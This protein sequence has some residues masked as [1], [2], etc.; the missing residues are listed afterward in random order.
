MVSPNS[1]EDTAGLRRPGRSFGP[2]RR[3]LL[4]IVACLA[5]VLA[6]AL[7]ALPWWLGPV[8]GRV[9]RPWGASFG[10]YER[11]G[12]TRF[13]LREVEVRQPGVRVAVSRV[14]S[15]TP[16]V[17]LWRRA[18]GRPGEI[19][20]E[21]WTVN[22]D[23][24]QS[25]AVATP[26]AAEGGWMPLRTTLRRI[27]NGLARWLPRA[28]AGAG[29]VRWPGG[30]LTLASA[31]WMERTLTV[32]RLELG[33]WPTRVTLTFPA[34]ADLLRLTFRTIDANGSANL[35]SREASVTGKVN[36]WE[37]DAALRAQFGEH[38]WLPAEATIQADAWQLPGARLKLGELY[39]TVRGQGKIAWSEG[40]FD[41]EGAI[42]GEPLTG[43]SAPPLAAA[44]R[45]HGDAQTF[46]VEAL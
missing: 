17:W 33:P 23:R 18:S 15:D 44:L 39:A 6:G 3:R 40:H 11:I 2:T 38:G 26:A 43:K 35:E 20:A 45:G 31:T 24:P 41:A 30:G 25:S 12:Y 10:S 27:A 32:E 5:A 16:L 37:Q 46:T 36:W 34:G 13:A 8:L 1:S 14:E 4:L 22:V 19:L 7:A 21:R 29:T 28:Q 9:G 42:K